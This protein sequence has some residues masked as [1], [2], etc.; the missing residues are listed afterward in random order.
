MV[1]VMFTAFMPHMFAALVIAAA[2]AFPFHAFPELSVS[3][4]V[5]LPAF[6]ASTFAV[7]TFIDHS[8]IAFHGCANRRNFQS[9]N[10]RACESKCQHGKS[11]SKAC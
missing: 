2:A 5:T 7:L 6:T 1:T 3:V 8:D 10:W 11:E 9:R 4:P